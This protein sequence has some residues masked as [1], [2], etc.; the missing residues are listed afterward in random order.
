[1]DGFLIAAHVRTNHIHAIV[2]AEVKP[3][4][5]MNDLKS[6]ASRCLNQSGLD[7]P[8][9]KCWA[10]HGSTRWLRDRKNIDAALKYLA[11]KQGDVMAI[12]VAA[13]Q[14]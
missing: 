8:D 9:R 10:R 7:T 14:R 1:V 6:Y 2:D 3:E 11:E 5:I 4:R 13:R 12:Y